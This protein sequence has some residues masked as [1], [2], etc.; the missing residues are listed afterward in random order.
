MTEHPDPSQVR[1]EYILKKSLKMLTEKWKKKTG[2]YLYVSEQFRSIRQ[3]LTVQQIQNE[4]SIK[5]YET[6]A[7]IA[8][9]SY[10]LPQ[11][12]QCQ[13]AL[14]PLYDKGIKG[15]SNEFFAYRILY[16]AL[17]E[18]NE[19]INIMALIKEKF[20]KKKKKYP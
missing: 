18:K 11:F 4:F 15:N 12:N 1:P 20:Q 6:H 13:T 2:D 14:I 16:T 9:E 8:L 10:D 3:D 17:Y 19:M 5:V 7:R